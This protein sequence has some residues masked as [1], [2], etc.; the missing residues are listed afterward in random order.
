MQKEVDPKRRVMKLCPAEA[1]ARSK[2]PEVI[3]KVTPE[4]TYDGIKLGLS[5]D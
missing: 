2:T 4:A 1:R 5:W 3:P